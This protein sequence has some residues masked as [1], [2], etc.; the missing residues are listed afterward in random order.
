MLMAHSLPKRQWNI[1]IAPEAMN[2]F[3]HRNFKKQYQ[4]NSQKIK[5]RFKERINIF[6]K[7]PFDPLLHNHAL[8]GHL[9]GYRS[10]DITGDVRAIYKV[11]D[12]DT[13]E[14][15]LIGTHHELYGK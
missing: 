2:I 14:F 12:E 11:L 13:V 15:A 6:S 10:I 5:Q 7:D 9:E 1:L 8:A 4:K 3:F